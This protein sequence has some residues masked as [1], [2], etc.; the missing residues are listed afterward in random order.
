MNSRLAF[1]PILIVSLI[2]LTAASRHAQTTS[3]H[4]DS[5]ASQPRVAL[6]PC[7][8][9]GIEGEVLCG[10]YEVYENR[11]ARAGR[12]IKLK[13]VVLKA[14]GKDRA[15]DAYTFINGGPGASATQAAAGLAQNLTS[16]RERRD[17]LLVD[18]R[19]VG[20][21]HALDCDFFD[22]RDLQSY[23]GSF[24]PAEDVRRCR[25]K[26]DGYADLKLYTTPIAMDDLDE[27][28][29][30]LGYDQL[31]IEGGSYG[32]RAAL[33]YLKRHPES[34]RTMILGGVDPTSYPM[35]LDFARDAQRALDGLLDDCGTDAQCHAAFPHAREEALAVFERLKKSPVEVEVLNPTTG[36]AARVK[37]SRDLAGEAV[38]YMLYSPDS[39]SQI[40]LV[41]H[42]AA[43]GD[44][45][46]L[47]ELAL[48]YRFGI[49]SSGANGMYL[50]VT[51]A[52]DLPRVDSKEAARISADTFLGDYRARQ[53]KEACAL[54]ERAD[55]PAWF[56]E[57]TRSDKPVLLFTGALDPVTPPAHAAEAAKYLPNSLNLVVPH[58]GHGQDGLVGIE[59]LDR[60]LADFIERGTTKGLDTSCVAKLR[61]AG[62]ATKPLELKLAHLS[63]DEL[64]KFAGHYTDARGR[65]LVFEVA[66][67]KLKLT[68]PDG[69][70][71]FFAPVSATKFRAA[72]APGRTLTFETKD[73]R[74]QSGTVMQDDHVVATLT[75]KT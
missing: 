12:K 40:P 4:A 55:V 32:T 15:P 34:V 29:A 63:A 20:G 25:Q 24:Q 46:P 5:A 7:K 69:S 44:F 56:Y 26:F 67:G 62:F 75:P 64:Q 60:L 11:E 21:S 2:A 71:A 3:Q 28:R 16:V 47:A 30:A 18:Q 22:P 17:I 36:D 1:A 57:P 19:G 61:R 59:C 72:G 8:V 10:E 54:W 38:R 42:Q 65:E 58:G 33:V 73:G 39:A 37:L 43:Q 23:L 49:V 51:C 53:Q 35:P 41:L 48:S 14:T 45:T 6:A 70:T 31:N 27:V 9:A 50:S 66:G 52:E 74:V 13:I 68:R